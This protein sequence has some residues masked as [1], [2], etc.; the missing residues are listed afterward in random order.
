M[1]LI[2]TSDLSCLGLGFLFKIK[3]SAQRRKKKSAENWSAP[4]NILYIRI[5]IKDNNKG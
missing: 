5:I 2:F 4:N 3:K 1:S